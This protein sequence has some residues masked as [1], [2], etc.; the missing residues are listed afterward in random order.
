M[1]PSKSV[2]RMI[3]P[4]CGMSYMEGSPYCR[5]CGQLLN[6]V[7]PTLDQPE[8]ALSSEALAA[9]LTEDQDVDSV[10]QIL[11]RASQILTYKEEIEYIATANKTVAGLV[12][13]CMIATDK[14]LINYKKK[15]LGKTELDDC[16]W[17]DVHH[18]DI[19]AGRQ[20][21]LIRVATTEGW[22]L[23]VDS[24]PKA[25]AWR[26]FELGAQHN[27]R[28]RMKLKQALAAEAAAAQASVPL[29]VAPVELSALA[30]SQA[31]PRLEME[32]FVQQE[33]APDPPSA[34]EPQLMQTANAPVAESLTPLVL[35]D[36]SPTPPNTGSDATLGPLEQPRTQVATPEND[37]A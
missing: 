14:R 29:S 7:A 26:L 17:R 6:D 13:D 27:L 16:S 18:I 28:L 24:L 15:L 4:N 9:F 1:V 12:P 33:V 10:R 11:Q 2:P 20:G 25:Q 35:P 30:Q 31:T 21:F 36:P 3:C 32:H 34:V 8:A 5:R 22:R 19:K 23:T 37:P